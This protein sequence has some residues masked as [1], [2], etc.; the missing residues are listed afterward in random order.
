MRPVILKKCRG[1]SLDPQIGSFL[2]FGNQSRYVGIVAAHTKRFVV[3]PKREHGTCLF[4][5]F[6]QDGAILRTFHI[7]MR[8]HSKMWLFQMTC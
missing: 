2:G 5:C 3:L 6:G 4:C 7:Q 8:G 1:V